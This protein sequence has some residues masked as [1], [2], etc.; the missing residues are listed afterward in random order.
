I[1]AVGDNDV[2]V[3]G[4]NWRVRL[5]P[6][7]MFDAS[8]FSTLASALAC[9]DYV[10]TMKDRGV[11]IV[12]TNN[13]WGGDEFSASLRHAIDAQRRRGIPFLA[14]AGKQEGCAVHNTPTRDT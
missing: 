14:G 7:K 5:L 2:G 3:V 6:C 4:V 12:A 11:N 1:G 10:A 13:S 9:L 8:G